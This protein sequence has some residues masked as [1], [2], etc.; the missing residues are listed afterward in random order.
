[1]PMKLL[2]MTFNGDRLLIPFCLCAIQIPDNELNT[3]SIEIIVID[4][5]NNGP[6]SDAP[7]DESSP[8][9]KTPLPLQTA[10]VDEAHKSPI[11]DEK[12][13]QPEK[14]SEE[15]TKDTE[16]DKKKRF[17]EKLPTEWSVSSFVLIDILFNRCP[18]KVFSVP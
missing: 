17:N 6:D 1:M 9:P 11:E 18:D 2:V 3:S 10:D 8:A 16:A 13:K 12:S 4:E 5:D 7:E 15:K 14:A